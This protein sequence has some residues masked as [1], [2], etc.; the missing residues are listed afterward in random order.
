MRMYA[1]VDV[2]KTKLWQLIWKCSD[3]VERQKWRKKGEKK[4]FYGIINMIFLE[5]CQFLLG[6]T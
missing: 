3:R 4:I 5:A 6:Q 2:F 1:H